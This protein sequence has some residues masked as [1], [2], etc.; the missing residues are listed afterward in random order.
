MRVGQVRS[1]LK[2]NRLVANK[3][4]KKEVD[5]NLQMYYSRSFGF[6]EW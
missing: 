5:E 2:A 1:D 4:A 6:S 3:K